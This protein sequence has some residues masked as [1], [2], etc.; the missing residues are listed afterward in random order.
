MTRTRNILA[1]LFALTILGLPA[2]AGSIGLQFGSSGQVGGRG[3]QPLAGMIREA[4]MTVGNQT[5]AT[6]GWLSFTTGKLSGLKANEWLF[7]TGGRFKSWGCVD[8]DLDGGKCDKKDLHGTLLTG[9]FKRAEL[10]K[11]GKNTFTLNGQIWVTLSPVLA[12]Q[13]GL[14]SAVQYLVSLKL[15]FVGSIQ[16]GKL[17]STSIV[18]GSLTPAVPEPTALVLLGFGAVIGA[19]IHTTLRVRCAGIEG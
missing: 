8:I 11:T 12:K 1:A 17:S 2:W 3:K 5:F 6:T 14:S 16:S 9:T 18:G 4:N 7:G 13:F 10:F 19:F 15:N